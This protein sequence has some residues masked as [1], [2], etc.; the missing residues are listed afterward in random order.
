MPS[1]PY[2]ALSARTLRAATIGT[3]AAWALLTLI[4]VW[5]VPLS[6]IAGVQA[7]LEARDPQTAGAVLASFEP[8]LTASLS[9]LL[10]FDFLYDVVHNNA[11]ALFAV[12]GAVGRRTAAA[13]TVAAT[14]AWILWLD[15]ALNVVENL[16]FLHVLRSGSVAALPAV[17]TIF[18]FRAATLGLA[19]LVGA[20]LH[21]SAWRVRRSTAR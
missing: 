9:F 2:E 13:Q 6:D 11:A 16:A 18:E 21:A 5:A 4:L 1:H 12:W 7:L 8:T 20:G 10:G 17:S 15:T 14:T 3:G 19:L